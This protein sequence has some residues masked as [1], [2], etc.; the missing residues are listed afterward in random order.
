MCPKIIGLTTTKTIEL[1]FDERD[2]LVVTDAMYVFKTKSD[3][4]PWAVMAIMQSGV[5]LFLY[6]TA[7]QGESRVI[8]QVKAA[9]LYELPFPK[10]SAVVASPLADLAKQ[11]TK[12]N[13]SMNNDISERATA[14]RMREC[15]SLERKIEDEVR[16]LYQIVDDDAKIID[17]GV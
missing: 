5:F 1:V 11:L 3:I 12:L 9:K 6:R 2:D 10:Y 8:P 4:S 17:A 14:A 13:D 7:N 15:A 16:K